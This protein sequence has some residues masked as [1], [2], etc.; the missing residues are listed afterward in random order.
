[1][2]Q[3]IIKSLDVSELPVR[4]AKF[5]PRKRWIICGAD[6]MHIRVYNY[7]TGESEKIFEAHSDYIRFIAV[8]PTQPLVLT[9]SD[10]LSI[11]LWNWEKNWYV[12]KYIHFIFKR[13][14][15]RTFDGHTHFVMQLVFSPKDPNVFASC[16]LDSTIRLWSTNKSTPNLTLDG[17]S[18]GVNCIDFYHGADKPYLISGSDDTYVQ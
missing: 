9:C 1:M 10:D 6:D 17:H 8:H 16:S 5:V 15:Q 11:K 2:L 3:Q 12:H 13:E 4:C 14:L 18:K 7:N